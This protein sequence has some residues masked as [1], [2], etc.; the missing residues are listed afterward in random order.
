MIRILQSSSIT[1]T[2]PSDC[3]VSYQNTHWGLGLTSLQ[4]SSWYIQQP[5]PSG[6]KKNIWNI[7][8]RLLNKKEIKKKIGKRVRWRKWFKRRKNKRNKGVKDKKKLETMIELRKK[9]IH[10]YIHTYR[11][12]ERKKERKKEKCRMK[13]VGLK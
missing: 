12:I 6:Q 13:K 9:Q 10:T 8:K 4:R 7:W 2:S 1:G 5:Q 3:L 11:K